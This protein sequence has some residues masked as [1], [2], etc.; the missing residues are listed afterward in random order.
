M[1]LIGDNIVENGN[2]GIIRISIITYLQ[3]FTITKIS[4]NFT[5]DVVIIS[6]K[7][8]IIIDGCNMY[9]HKPYKSI[10]PL[11]MHS[12]NMSGPIAQIWFL[13]QLYK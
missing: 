6:S 3:S 1:W 13:V 11:V 2:K 7:F 12:Y 10:G 8:F 4:W 9:T 5:N